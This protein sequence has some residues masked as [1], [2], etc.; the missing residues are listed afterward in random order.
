VA[1]LAVLYCAW[2]AWSTWPAVDRHDDRR[3]EQLIARV[4]L[5][6]SD[7]D[8]MLISDMNWELENVLLYVGRHHRPD[9]T[10]TRLADVLPHFPFLV[11]EQREIGRSIVLTANAAATV[12]ATYGPL[13]PLV[14]DDL[15]PAVSLSSQVARMPEGAP[16]VMTLLTPPPEEHL[17]ERDLAA[18]LQTLTGGRLP[19][20]TP[21]SF[22]LIAG[23]RGERPTVYRSADRP[24][25]MS[26]RILEEPFTV[27]LDSWLPFDTFR[28]PGFG[29]VLRGREHLQIL[30]RGVNVVWIARD[31][32]ASR[33]VYAAGLF[34][35][36]ARYRLVGGVAPV[37]ARVKGPVT[38]GSGRQAEP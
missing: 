8:A 33:P 11:A 20:R 16:Y 26:F 13:F 3:G 2:R 27:R 18:T 4:T 6:V 17:D 32:R 7:P 36:E 34:A 23:I 24:F 5:G 28:R 25:T 21:G 31:G 1:A 9:L 19:S 30:E 22:E 14:E 38:F 15:V 35:P 37:L 10:W 29:H 12:V